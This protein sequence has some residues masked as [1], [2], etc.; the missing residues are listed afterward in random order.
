MSVTVIAIDIDPQKIQKA[1]H[2]AKI[3]GVE[4]KIEFITADFLE[5][6]STL[7]ADAVFLSP[8]WGGPKYLKQKVYE[9][10]QDLQPVS[11]TKLMSCAKKISNNIGAF[12]PRNSNTHAVSELYFATEKL[13]LQFYFLQL[14]LSGLGG[15]VDIEQNFLNDKLIALTVYYN[16]LIH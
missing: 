8:P 11:F 7:K 9:L 6:A 13:I 16:D 1:R 2:N 10:E 15:K 12:L 14:F 4:D 5:L 3:Y